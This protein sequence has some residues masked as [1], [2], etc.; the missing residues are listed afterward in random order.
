MRI[1]RAISHAQH[2]RAHDLVG[3]RPRTCVVLDAANSVENIKLL[4][5][6]VS[7]HAKTET[8]LYM[9]LLVGE[10]GMVVRCYFRCIFHRMVFSCTEI[11]P[12]ADE[13]GS[14]ALG[15]APPSKTYAQHGLRKTRAPLLNR[16]AL[17]PATD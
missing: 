2:A 7:T 15:S 16:G 11:W 4:C 13:P 9:Y 8:Y 3:S 6:D 14:L 17:D 12:N 1:A 5:L 10:C